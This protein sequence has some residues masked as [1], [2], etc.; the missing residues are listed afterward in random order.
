MVT[1]T[2]DTIPTIDS[3]K[4]MRSSLG[5]SGSRVVGTSHAPSPR[6]MAATGRL[7][8]KI[9]PHQN[10]WSRAPPVSGPRATA[11]PTTPVQTPMAVARS[12]SS[13]KVLVRMASVAGKM[14]AAARPMSARAAMSMSVEPDRPANNEKPANADSPSCRAPF[15]P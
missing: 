7:T 3:T 14:K 6:A 8:K 5:A 12:L 13:L 15:R 9:E 10:R 2:T 4:P 11:R 1:Y